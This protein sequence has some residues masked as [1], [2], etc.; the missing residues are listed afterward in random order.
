MN[1]FLAQF[2]TRFS[3]EFVSLLLMI[4]FIVLPAVLVISCLIRASRYFLKA[5]K[6]QKLIRLELGKLAEELQL[7]RKELKEVKEQ[8]KP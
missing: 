3:L 4:I 6:E 7:I 5:G 8:S 2:E 1:Y